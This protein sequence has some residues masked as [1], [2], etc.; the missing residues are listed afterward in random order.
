MRNS[1]AQQYNTIPSPESAPQE[2][3]IDRLRD[4]LSR[5]HDTIGELEDIA[6]RLFGG[7][8]AKDSAP[9]PVPN[10]AVDEIIY[11]AEW[12]V[13]RADRVLNR[14]RILA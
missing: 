4:R 13:E 8:P 12:L 11:S 1:L 9:P 6:E 10:G 7:V 14:L 5:V 2:K 3:V